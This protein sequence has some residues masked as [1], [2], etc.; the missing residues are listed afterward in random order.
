M[1]LVQDLRYALR[2]LRRN[3]S[4]TA[5]IILSLAVGIGANTAIF[6]VVDGLLL[7]PLPYP[8]ADRLAILWLRSPGIGIPQDWPSPGEYMDIKTQNRVFEE[9]AICIDDSVTLTGNG[10]AERIDLMRTSSSLLRMLGAEPLLG[11]SLSAEDDVPGKAPV[12]VLTWALWQ[13]E[14]GG[15]PRALGRTMLFNGKPFI[16]AGVLRKGFLLNREVIPT[17]GGIE[18]PE[19]FV[20]LPLGADAAH[21]RGNENFN[22]LARLKPGITVQQAQAD[23]SVIARRIREQDHR[24]RTFTISVVPLLE[25]VVGDVRRAVLVLLGSV[26]LVLLIACA[27]VANLLLSRA[28]AREKETVI[29]AALGAGRRR[30]IRQL[31]TESVLLGICGGLAGLAVAFGALE[32]VRTMNPGN[33]PRLED[34]GLNAGVL[35]FTF[36]ISVLTGI[37]FGVA[38]A[39]RVSRV[40]LNTT[41]RSGG[42]LSDGDTGLVLR[43]HGLRAV[44]VA[45]E[46]ALSLMLLIGAGLLVRSFARLAD[47]PPGF[48]PDHVI[49]MR[50][51]VAG[52]KYHDDKVVAGFFRD[53][54]DRIRHLPGVVG[55]GAVSSLPLTPS[56][57]WGHVTIEGYTPPPNLPELQTDLRVTTPGYF[58]AMQIPLLAGRFFDAHDDATAQKVVLVDEKLALRFWP[59]GDAVGKRLRPGG[60][61]NPWWTI[62]G[63]VGVVKQYGL[64]TE[65]RMALYFPE[66]QFSDGGLY[67]VARTAS[68][69]A[70]MAGPIAAAVHAIDPDVPVFDAATMHER[71]RASLARQR[72]SMT[73]LGAF[74]G[75]AL[76]LAVIGIYGVLSFLVTQATHDIGVRLAL[77][78]PRRTILRLVLRQGGVLAGAGI[79]A[80]ILGALALT[81]LMASLLFGV[82]ARDTLTFSAVAVFLALVALAATYIPARRAMRV[83]PMNALRYE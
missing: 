37:V 79:A 39:L 82:S 18:K 63:V 28:F 11:R 43:R 12:A 56:V 52:P 73:M 13:R 16:V 65:T 64:Q 22:V 59:H 6:S 5:V 21:D 70:F 4:L 38:P 68:D 44:L 24:D 25:Q 71:L 30:L 78:A 42:R 60:P 51:E 50:V 45:G 66:E 29:R 35:A 34:M 46:I 58:R 54:G 77:G 23:I 14:F 9:M 49:S 40:D 26:T 36:G 67:V 15:D 55:E 72:F 1:P 57:G 8:H 2:M 48:N 27:N 75:F 83:D 33:I 47:V 7:R 61:K 3:G 62:A 41:L 76:L 20:P 74:A 69:P 81:R 53:L 32:V 19:A 10:R 17:V 31:L 80:G